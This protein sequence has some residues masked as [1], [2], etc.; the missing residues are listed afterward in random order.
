LGSAQ[1]LWEAYSTP[2]IPRGTRRK[3]IGTEEVERKRGTG[4]RDLDFKDQGLGLAAP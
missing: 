4:K 3:G 1:N 2:Q